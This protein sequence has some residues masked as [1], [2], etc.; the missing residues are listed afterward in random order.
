MSSRSW[1]LSALINLA[2]VPVALLAACSDARDAAARA[3]P[4]LQRPLA[5][6]SGRILFFVQTVTNYDVYVVNVDGTGAVRLTHSPS[7][8]TRVP[9]PPIVS[10]DGQWL[11]VV[12]D[13]VTLVRLDRPGETARLQRP[14]G[15]MAWSPD[16]RQLASLD[17]DAEKRLHLNVFNADGSGDVRDLAASWPAT[18]AGYEQSVSDFTWSPDGSRFAFLMRTGVEKGARGTYRWRTDLYVA[19]ADG[20]GLRNLS[21]EQNAPLP[22]GGV[23]WSPDGKR[24]A[25]ESAKGIATL[26]SDLKWNEFA[27]QTHPSRTSQRPVWSPDSTR[28]AWFNQW[29]IVTS[30]AD[31]GKQLEVTRGRDDGVQPAWSHDG[32]RLAF[33]CGELSGLCVMNSDGS[34]LTRVIDFRSGAS[35]FERGAQK[36]SFPV[37]LPHLSR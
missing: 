28:L 34:G 32:L 6:T 12:R 26:D 18:T 3:D 7:T 13:E 2:F 17:I 20:S 25:F 23:A 9:V 16:N 15:W 5:S 33:V 10:P 24:L 22:L 4:Q 8:T 35:V 37:W 36:I 30:D 31:G 11:P 19:P 14:R 29:G 27:V 21:L 1:V